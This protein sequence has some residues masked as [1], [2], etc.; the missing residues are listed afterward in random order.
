LTIARPSAV[1]R[2]APERWESAHT[3]AWAATKA[4]AHRS[5]HC[6]LACPY[7][8]AIGA[9]AANSTATQ[10]ATAAS[11]P[12]GGARPVCSTSSGSTERN[13]ATISGSTTQATYS[14]TVPIPIAS[15]Y[16]PNELGLS[17]RAR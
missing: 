13:L 1:S 10:T 17:A 5:G 2:V 11:R 7:A 4:A 15:T 14:A 12:D 8:L 6:R 3:S 9:A 16:S